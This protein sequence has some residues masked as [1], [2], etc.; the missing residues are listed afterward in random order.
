[1]T[2]IPPNWSPGLLLLH[3]NLFSTQDP[4]SSLDLLSTQSS[5][6]SSLHWKWNQTCWS[7]PHGP[8]T[9]K[10]ITSLFSPFPSIPGY[11]SVSMSCP[12]SEHKGLCRDFP[13][14]RPLS[15]DNCITIP[16][17]VKSLL[18]NN[19][20]IFTFLQKGLY[21]FFLA[22]NSYLVYAYL[23]LFFSPYSTV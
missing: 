17:C 20:E 9:F 21:F 23:I 14:P 6:D 5:S 3:C 2:I 18:K 13:L 1:M 22:L 7:W 4:E 10:Y 11:A 16:C 15:L 12:Y 19:M 8:T